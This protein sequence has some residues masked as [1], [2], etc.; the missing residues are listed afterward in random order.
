MLGTSETALVFTSGGPISAIC[1]EL[2]GLSDE[3]ALQLPLT[4][5]NCGITRLRRTPSGLRLSTFNE[6][7]HLDGPGPSLVTFL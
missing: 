7:G 1:R 6:H 3:T 2:L 4:L 5:V